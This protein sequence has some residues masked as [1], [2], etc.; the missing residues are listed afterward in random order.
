MLKPW[1]KVADLDE[2]MQNLPWIFEIRS[3]MLKPFIFEALDLRICE[4]RSPGSRLPTWRR[5]YVAKAPSFL[6]RLELWFPTFDA[7]ALDLPNPISDSKALDL[8]NRIIAP[9]LLDHLEFHSPPFDAQAM[10]LDI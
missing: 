8:R 3:Q 9:S 10:D 6:D 4:I 5:K 7:K 2:C 1:I